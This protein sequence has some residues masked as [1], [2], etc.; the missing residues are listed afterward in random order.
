MSTPGVPVVFTARLEGE[1]VQIVSSGLSDVGRVR[2]NN[3]DSFRIVEA[4]NLFILSDGMGGEAHGDVASAMAV[5]VIKKYCE[6][7]NEHSGATLLEEVPANT[8]SRTRRLRNSLAQ[9]N[10]QIY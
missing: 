4:L 9:P 1:A 5:D 6:S 7:E 8:I 3:E 10:F 2:T